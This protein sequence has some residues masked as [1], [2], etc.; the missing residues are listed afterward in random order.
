V[1]NNG[2]A[3]DREP[4]IYFIGPIA[5]PAV[6][7]NTSLD[8]YG[9]PNPVSGPLIMSLTLLDSLP[10]STAVYAAN[11]R[12]GAITSTNGSVVAYLQ[13]VR[14]KGQRSLF[15]IGPGANVLQLDQQTAGSYGGRINVV[16]RDTYH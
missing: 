13:V 6:L 2:S 4:L 8:I 5:A 9:N 1:T 12:T 16:S 3:N 15:E 10:A 7:Y 14:N 11:G